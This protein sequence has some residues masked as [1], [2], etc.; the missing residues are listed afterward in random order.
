MSARRKKVFKMGVKHG[1]IANAINRSREIVRR[2]LEILKRLELIDGHLDPQD[3][4]HKEIAN[5][6]NL[7]RDMVKRNQE[8]LEYL[9]SIESPLGQNGGYIP[10]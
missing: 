2:E 5:A 7:G 9:E 10:A 8:I 3:V 6:I 4:K 1:E